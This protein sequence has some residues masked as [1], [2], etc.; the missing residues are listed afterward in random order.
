MKIHDFEESLA[1]VKPEEEKLDRYLEKLG[2]E[3]VLATITEEKRGIDRYIT[4]KGITLAVEYKCDSRAADTGNAF[5]EIVSNSRTDKPGWVHTTE[6]DWVLYFIVKA[7][8][9]YVMWLRP[10]VIRSA[11]PAWSDKYRT[12][13]CQ[14]PSYCSYG[15]LVPLDRLKIIAEKVEEL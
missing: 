15:L 5:I 3:I 8:K 1:K 11:M 10:S 7:E 9:P 12:A 14:N 4:T 6:A 13:L 2:Y